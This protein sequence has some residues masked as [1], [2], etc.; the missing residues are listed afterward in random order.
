M[1]APGKS[2]SEKP[3]PLGELDARDRAAFAAGGPTRVE[4]QRQAGK[5]TARE[6]V[7]RLLDAGSFVEMGRFVSAERRLGGAHS[8]RRSDHVPG[9]LPGIDQ[10]HGGI[11]VH[12]AKLLYAFSEATVPKR[13][14]ITRKVSTRAG[15]GKGQPPDGSSMLTLVSSGVPKFGVPSSFQVNS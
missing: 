6:R 8:G 5:L 13:T 10:E 11:I 1:Y 4:K 3:S 7:D 15:S 9:F 14:V 2:M 12:G